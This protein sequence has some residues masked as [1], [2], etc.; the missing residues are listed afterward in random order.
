[1]KHLRYIEDYSKT[2]RNLARD[3]VDMRYDSVAEFFGYLAEELSEDAK[4]DG[5]RGRT[6][7][8]GKLESAA[9]DSL[10]L[11]K[12]MLSIWN[13]CKKHME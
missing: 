4:N 5:K 7:L 1:M 3:I 10:E 2:L 11:Q 9:R 12:K 13:L 6:Q 8:S